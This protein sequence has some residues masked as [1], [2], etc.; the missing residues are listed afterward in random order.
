M[1]TVLVIV[2]ALLTFG[3][4]TAWAQRDQMKMQEFFGV[5]VKKRP[6]APPTPA[7]A[8]APAPSTAAPI[9]PPAEVQSVVVTPAPVVNRSA[10]RI[11]DTVAI[12]TEP[13]AV[14]GELLSRVLRSAAHIRDTYIFM[15]GWGQWGPAPEFQDI[16]A[17]DLKI[18]VAGQFVPFTQTRLVSAKGYVTMRDAQNKV[19][20]MRVEKVLVRL[21]RGFT[22]GKAQLDLVPRVGG[23]YAVTGVTI[24]N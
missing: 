2:I 6:A 10:I 18:S 13:G 8:A 20:G 5:E 12:D 22:A 16:A 24:T 23:G 9:P 3:S 17:K 14:T 11:V 1:K 7:P 21:A 15:V 19:V 4:D